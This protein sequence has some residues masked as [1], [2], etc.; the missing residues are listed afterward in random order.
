MID[1][2]DFLRLGAGA[3]LGLA[4]TR[5]CAQA[6]TSTPGRIRRYVRLG[7]TELKVS[8]ISFGSASSSDAAL[9]RHALERGVNYFDSAESY[10]WG[11]A[12]EA[13]G[14]AV[15]GKRDQV[16]LSSKTKAGA[17][18]T[19]AEMMK[20]LEGSLRRLRSD[21]VDIYFNHAVNDVARMQNQEW[22]EFTELAKRQGKIRFRGMSGHGSHLVECLNYALDHDEVDVILTAYN[23]GQDPSFYDRLRH[24]FHW[25]AIQP[26]LPP[27]LEKAKRKD[28]GVLA[29]KTLMGARLNDMRPY[30]RPGS[31]FS[32]AA[33]RWVLSRPNVD[34]LLISMTSPEL[35]DEY[36]A[37]SGGT[38]TSQSDLELLSRYTEMRSGNYCLPGCNACESSCPHGVAIAEVL[39]TRM[40][41]VD[42]RD[43]VLA[44]AEYA[45][46]G[47]GASAC[48]S[49]A[50]RSCLRACPLGIPIA[51]LTRDAAKRLS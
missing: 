9:V 41:A 30:E 36:V 23:V 18:D 26:D 50:H 40:Y 37:A 44:R 15:Q 32:Q 39:R 45:E 47:D 49:C 29:M 24:T 51:A 33:F 4:A 20:A 11:G 43:T 22:W 25:A 12:E 1:R 6:Q 46:L 17:S 34:A 42:Y 35:I 10:R 8:D 31:T 5:A 16:V 27:V 21:Y 3:A 38:V 28:V 7:R 48:L 2:R 13:I 19:R 14:E